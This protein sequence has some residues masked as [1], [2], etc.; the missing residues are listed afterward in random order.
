MMS[1]LLLITDMLITDYSSSEGDFALLNRPFILFQN[2]REDYLEKDRTFYFDID[3]SPFKVVMNQFELI[4]FVKNLDYFD[5][6]ENCKEILKFY[7]SYETGKASDAVG[8]YIIS[9]IE[10]DKS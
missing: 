7:G 5:A 3:K 2:D 8:D 6:E 4:S 10:C 9:N 1:E